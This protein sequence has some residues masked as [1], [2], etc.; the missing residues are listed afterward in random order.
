MSPV[1]LPDGAPG[2]GFDDLRYAPVL[3]KVLAPG[4]RSGN[5]DL[6]DPTTLAVDAIGGFSA[7]TTFAAGSHS[8]G[9]T[10]A[11]EGAG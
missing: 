4:G 6:V 9:T 2:I 10:S 3:K 11:D 8:S 1:P 5:L 7:S